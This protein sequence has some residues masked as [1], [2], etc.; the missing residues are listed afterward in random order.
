MPAPVIG[1]TTRNTKDLKYDHSLVTSPKTYPTAIVKA[2]G[3]P[4]LIPTN[5]T[6]DTYAELLNRLDG[7]I[8][9]GGGDIDISH[10]QGQPHPKIYGIDAERDQQEISLVRMAA[11]T[12]LPM[13]GICRGFQVINVTLGGT[14]F[15]HIMDQLPDALEHS[16][17]PANPPDYPAH[18]VTLVPGTRLAAILQAEKVWVNSLHHQGAERLAPGLI[19]AGS[20][21][22]GLLEAFELPNHPFAIAVQW[23]PEWMPDDEK[24]QLLFKAFIAAAAARIG[25]PA[26]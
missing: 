24:M 1:L 7:I 10:F 2:G 12:G 21:P 23:H 8:F 20:A 5:L 11:Q 9:T 26:Q 13:L 18:E 19:P 4:L 6:P 25:E 22:D 14:L 17:F 15:T 3:I 16:A